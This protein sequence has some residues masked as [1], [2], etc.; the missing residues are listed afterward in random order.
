MNKYAAVSLIALLVVVVAL[1][2]YALFEAG[3]LDQAQVALSKRYVA[4]GADMYVENCATCHGADGLGIGAMPALNN[5]NL[6]KADRQVLYNTIAHSPHGTA[7]SAWHVDDGGALNS[8]QVEGLVTLIMTADWTEVSRLATVRGFREPARTDPNV[9]LAKMEAGDQEDPHECRACHEEP[10]VHAE[11][12]GFNCSRC[13][14]LEAW[15]PALLLRHTFALDHGEKGQVA[16]QTCHT[17][18]Y[19]E[20]TCYGCHDHELAD[21]ETVHAAEGIFELEPCGECHPT[22]ASGEARRLGYGVRGDT[23]SL[24][25]PEPEGEDQMTGGG[26]IEIPSLDEENRVR[27]KGGLPGTGR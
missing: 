9:D 1:P 15:K 16:C 27:P 20:N 24:P 22:G 25:R 18:T 2:V 13:H 19:F 17:T 12:F 23:G 6:A 3:R 8:F 10:E 21:M 7:M 5:P 26:T 11:R 4:E 14:T